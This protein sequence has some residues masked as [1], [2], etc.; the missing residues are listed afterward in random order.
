[1]TSHDVRDMLNLPGEAAPRP[2]K[3]Q[4]TIAPRTVLKGLAREVQNLGGDNPIAI[5]PEFTS[6][7]Q[8][9]GYNKP[10]AKWEF[11]A[12]KNSARQ[13]KDFVL[14][15][16]RRKAEVPTPAIAEDG[17]VE[18]VDAMEVEQEPEESTF[19]KYNVRISCP[20][21]DEE[22][23]RSKLEDPEWT[24]EETDYLLNLVQEFDLRWPVI[25]DRYE[26]TPTVLHS[27]EGSDDM[28]IIPVPKERTMEDMKARYYFIAATMMQINKKVEIMNG[29]EFTLLEQMRNY[30]PKV[31]Q[32]RKQFAE[33]S[34][35]RTKDDAREEESLLLELKRI[36]ARSQKLSE[37]RAELY[38]RLEAP[39]SS[40]NIGM[41]TS[42]QGLNQLLQQLMAADKSKKNRR[43]IMGGEGVSP[44]T[45]SSQLGQPPSF[46]RRESS[47]TNGESISGPS[48]SANNKKG[49]QQNP[50]ERR[51]LNSQ[52]QALFG[53]RT[54]DRI[55]TSGPAF[56]HEKIMRA[57]TTKSA[58]QQSKIDNVITELGLRPRLTMATY[59][60]GVAYEQLLKDISTLLDVRK[61]SEKLQG[62]INTIQALIAQKEEQARAEREGPAAEAEEAKAN[63]EDGDDAAVENVEREQSAVPSVRPS[64]GHKRSA[65][66]LSTV[67]DKSTKRQK[68]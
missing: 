5:V 63:G 47:A 43:S 17:S 52:E 57:K 1:M 3:K 18:K 25:W 60:V 35:A 20:Q 49:P 61:N 7:K 14:R 22:I 28:A 2:T 40:G 58:T 6:Y 64:S 10:A 51:E 27:V 45:G 30:N 26:Y 24:K 16:W 13:D 48:G 8:R 65:S 39:A 29:A 44:A 19:A 66:V 56:R 11:R 33:A 54:M 50:L 41:Y 31:E 55:T 23:Y 62:E 38:E 32:Q 34:F 37:E 36:L 9:P 15:H 4:K 21:Y 59:D 12:F 68:T 67:S 53:V 46:D 42:S